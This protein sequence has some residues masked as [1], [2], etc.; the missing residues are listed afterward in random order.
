MLEGPALSGHGKF[1]G[2]CSNYLA[3]QPA[4][5]TVY[6]F[7]R[8]PTIP[9]HPPARSVRSPVGALSTSFASWGSTQRGKGIVRISVDV[10]GQRENRV[11]K[12]VALRIGMLRYASPRVDSGRFV[13]SRRCRHYRLRSRPESPTGNVSDGRRAPLRGFAGNDRSPRHC[14]RSFGARG[15]LHPSGLRLLHLG[16]SE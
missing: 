7:V 9:F 14:L 16:W 2:V 3:A 13:A 10:L 4:E 8:M 12:H 15:K 5:A 6:A 11:F 1:R